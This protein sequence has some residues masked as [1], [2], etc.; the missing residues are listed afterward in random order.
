MLTIK[1]ALF[2]FHASILF[3]YSNFQGS[4]P[5]VWRAY[6]LEE[7]RLWRQLNRP[8]TSGLKA[9]F[10]SLLKSLYYFFLHKGNKIHTWFRPSLLFQD[11][12]LCFRT[13]SIA[14]YVV[15]C[16]FECFLFAT[17]RTFDWLLGV[18]CKLCC[19]R[20]PQLAKVSWT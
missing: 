19:I 2:I 3:L 18:S 4:S 9:Q 10:F 6:T 8:L 14:S 20:K 1:F 5:Y 16:D 17:P 13:V 12:T 7:S 11:L 15:H